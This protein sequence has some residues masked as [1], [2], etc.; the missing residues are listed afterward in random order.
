MENA[1][2]YGKITK[3]KTS[4][5]VYHYRCW[6]SIHPEQHS[7]S[8]HFPSLPLTGCLHTLSR[9]QFY[10]PVLSTRCYSYNANTGTKG[11]TRAT[12]QKD[13]GTNMLCNP[14]TRRCWALFDTP[15]ASLT[16]NILV[17]C[18]FSIIIQKLV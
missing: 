4:V 18:N 11:S 7:L 12:W 1:S 5:L 6:H 15:Q 8:V 9:R 16:T 10:C 17:L 2:K 13:L 3:P 14:Y